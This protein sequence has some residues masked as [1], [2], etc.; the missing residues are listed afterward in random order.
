MERRRRAAL[1]IAAALLIAAL[2]ERR[3]L[4]A[5]SFPQGDSAITAPPAAQ[6]TVELGMFGLSVLVRL[7]GG[8]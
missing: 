2:G 1:F 7:Q 6:A 5:L 4:L 3:P 8:R